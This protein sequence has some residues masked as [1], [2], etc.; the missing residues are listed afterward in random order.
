LPLPQLTQL[1]TAFSNLG[2]ASMP[3]GL[4]QCVPATDANSSTLSFNLLH[5]VDP[6]PVAFNAQLMAGP[7]V[8][9]LSGAVLATPAQATPGGQITVTGSNFPPS[10]FVSIGWTDT[11]TGKLTGSIV[12]VKPPTPGAP[13]LIRR[14]NNSQPIFTLPQV[15]PGQTYQVQVQDSDMLTTT[16]P[17][18]VVPLQAIGE[19]GLLLDYQSKG[20]PGVAGPPAQMPVPAG[21]AT[22]NLGVASVGANGGF[23]SLL[24]I[25]PDAVPGSSATLY[26]RVGQ[27]PIASATFT[28]VEKLQPVL[29]LVDPNSFTGAVQDPG[30]NSGYT[31]AVRG[32][33][34]P[35]TSPSGP[36]NQVGPTHVLVTINNSTLAAVVGLPASG[37]PLLVQAD[38]TFETSFVWPSNMF[39]GTLFVA[40]NYNLLANKV[41]RANA[42]AAPTFDGVL[43]TLVVTE[44]ALLQ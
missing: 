23:T 16:Q 18:N 25:P 35:V 22:A 10:N 14:S 12:T 1:A 38:G 17:S 24:T 44:G 26:A 43:A 37:G 30:V 33:N 42:W 20:K 39:D 29:Y 8:P 36:S 21:P 28:I 13:Y 5:A 4:M 34:F 3:L 40:G 2:L 11:C 32:E 41:Y 31:V 9:I 27:Q 15:Q 6:A 7:K 19:L